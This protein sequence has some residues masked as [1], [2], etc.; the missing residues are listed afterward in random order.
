MKIL[1]GLPSEGMGH[2]TR[3]NV[4]IAHL[5]KSHDVRVATSD[6][7][8]SFMQERF[9]GRVYEIKGFHL[10]Y[11]DGRV[12]KSST[13]S[14]LLKNG[15][16]DLLA[17]IHKYRLVHKEFQPD[18]VISDFDSFT[19]FYAKFN[20]L[21][22]ISV[23]NI[24]AMNRCKLDFPIPTSERNSYEIAK[25]IVKAKVANADY[26]LITS[27]FEAQ[28]RKKNTS[29]VP[30]ILREKILDATGRAGEHLLVYQTS[31][32]QNSLIPALNKVPKIPFIVYGFNKSESHDNVTL[33][34]FSEDGFIGDLASAKGVISNGG[35]SLLSE[36]VYLKKPVC[37]VPI[38]GQF[39]QYVNAAY[40]EQCGYGRHLPDFTADGIKAFL[41]DIAAFQDTVSHY[42]QDGNKETF[43]KLDEVIARVTK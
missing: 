38:K 32:S 27:F 13:A 43:K 11:K 10:A 14:L 6:R 1:Y 37:S 34:K 41:F 40:I 18:L 22:L 29:L 2:A 26:Y 7:A 30:P 36:A 3:S 20:K 23:D 24:Q 5:L 21:P 9:P 31:S 17:N 33:K 15:P 12:S 28:T 42:Q 25:N 16:K 39:E 19:F 4:I 35:F 8:F